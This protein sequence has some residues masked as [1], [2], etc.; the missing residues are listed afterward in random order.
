M[1]LVDPEHVPLTDAEMRE[2]LETC[3]RFFSSE[4]VLTSDSP[5]QLGRNGPFIPILLPIRQ[6]CE[7]AL[8][9]LQAARHPLSQCEECGANRTEPP[10]HWTP[11]S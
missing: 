3:L 1:G 2:Q 7:L 9:G 10:R 4:A 6:L 5:V 11:R 8:K